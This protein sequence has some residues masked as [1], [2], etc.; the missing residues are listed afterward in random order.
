MRK[1]NFY[2]LIRYSEQSQ[3]SD[4]ELNVMK[5]FIVGTECVMNL[6]TDT[7]AYKDSR[8]SLSVH[9]PY[10]KKTM[11]FLATFDVT[12]GTWLPCLSAGSF[13][14]LV[15]HSW[16]SS[17]MVPFLIPQRL[18]F[19]QHWVAGALG[20]VPMDPYTHGNTSLE[21]ILEW[22][23][24]L[25]SDSGSLDRASVCTGPS[26]SKLQESLKLQSYTHLYG[27][28]SSQTFE[29]TCKILWWRSNQ[30]Y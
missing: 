28:K 2:R 6:G 23:L 22:I 9:N 18:L 20:V 3:N 15:K 30:L 16:S 7:C 1:K 4:G 21:W 27:S 12:V 26:F 14:T 17:T 25:W 13:Q 10:H 29:Q 19:W 5:A 11:C 24:I 8:V